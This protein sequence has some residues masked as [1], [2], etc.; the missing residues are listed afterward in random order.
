M[1]GKSHQEFKTVP[2]N[3][4]LSYMD[5]HCCPSK[6]HEGVTPIDLYMLTGIPCQGKLLPFNRLN[7][8]SDGRWKQRLPLYSNELEGNNSYRQRKAQGLKVA[9]LK[10]FLQRYARKMNENRAAG[11]EYLIP[12][13]Y[14]ELE[15]LFVLCTLGQCLFPY[16]SSVVLIGFLEAL[17]YLKQAPTYDWGSAILLKIYMALGDNSTCDKD[18]FNAFWG[19]LEYWWYTYFVFRNLVLRIIPMYF[20]SYGSMI[21]RI[22]KLHRLKMVNMLLLFIRFNR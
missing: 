11:N 8:L 13:H 2:L 4:I 20:R 21:L 22:G 3:L 17:E 18:S 14:E 5:A 10:S 6:C 15:R 7:W 19:V 12:D 1:S 16:A 9:G